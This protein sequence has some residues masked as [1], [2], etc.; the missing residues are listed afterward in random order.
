MFYKLQKKKWN[1]PCYFLNIIQNSKMCYHNNSVSLTIP[2]TE[3]CFVKN[4]C[5][6]LVCCKDTG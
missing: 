3:K 2:M 4:N 5:H 6:S 1:F